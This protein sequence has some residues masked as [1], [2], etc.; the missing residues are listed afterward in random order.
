MKN[1]KTYTLMLLALCVSLYSQAQTDSS[2]VEEDVIINVGGLKVV[3]KEKT[4]ETTT[5]EDGDTVTRNT[6]VIEI[7]TTEDEDIHIEDADQQITMKDLS[8]LR[9]ALKGENEEEESE[10][11]FIDT[12]WNSFELGFN[13]LIN[14]DGKLEAEA[15]YEVMSVNAG[16]SIHFHWKIITQ[17]MNLYKDKVRLV[18]GIGLDFNNYRFKNDINLSVDSGSI[19]RADIGSINYKKN[20]LVTKLLTVPVLLNFKINPKKISDEYLY[21]SAGGNFGYLLGSHQKQVWE[22]N[23]KKENKIEGDYNLEQFRVGYEVQFGY[24]N[25]VLYGKYFPKSIFKTNQGPDLRTVSA[26]ILIGK[27]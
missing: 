20:K 27:V 10:P 23:G 2:E 6:E 4:S 7:T 18:Y 13:N 22:V 19:L 26:G 8:D 1:Y 25:V 14:A 5:N 3:V 9:N 12:K 16:N 24:K 17:A 15:G 21:I 11:S